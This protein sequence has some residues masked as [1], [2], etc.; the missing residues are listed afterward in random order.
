MKKFLLSVHVIFLLCS[1]IASAAVIPNGSFSVTQSLFVSGGNIGTGTPAS[2]NFLLRFSKVGETAS[3]KISNERFVLNGGM[4]L[5]MSRVGGDL[6]RVHVRGTIDDPTAIVYVNEVCAVNQGTNWV[7]P[8]VTVREG[9]NRLYV[10][11]FDP[12]E[13]ISGTVVTVTVDTR[14]PAMPTAVYEFVTHLST[15]RITGVKDAASE[16]WVRMA[17]AETLIPGFSGLASWFYDAVLEE[18]ENHIEFFLADSAGNKSAAFPVDIVLD[19]DAAMFEII[20]PADGTRTQ[21]A[22]IDIAGKIYD[23]TATLTVNGALITFSENRGFF[24]V[25]NV[26]LAQAGANSIAIHAQ[27]ITGFSQDQVINIIRDDQ[28]LLPPTL[29]QLPPYAGVSDMSVSGNCDVDGD[30]SIRLNQGA[31]TNIGCS[32]GRWNY[33]LSFFVGENLVMV[34]GRDALGRMIAGEGAV[35]FLDITPPTS[36]VV[37]DGGSTQSSTSKLRV[38]WFSYDRETS[39]VDYEYAVST[40]PGPPPSAF[41]SSNGSGQVNITGD[42]KLNKTYYIHVRARNAAGLF[43]P[44]G[45]SDGI[46]ISDNEIPTIADLLPEI[47]EVRYPNEPIDWQ[48][49]A[50]DPDDDILQFKYALNGQTVFHFSEKPKRTYQIP[51]G[52]FG[53]QEVLGVVRDDPQSTFQEWPSV[54]TSFYVARRPIEP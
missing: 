53:R 39:V 28:A 12:Q 5:A 8:F 2:E 37:S 18:G 14:P 47:G 41:V 32:A 21:S 45:V 11:S 54:S 42:Y 43:S 16:L 50:H 3:V 1:G 33:S 13:N 20:A 44:T 52:M 46:K 40:T 36:P 10:S 35:V 27:S 15:Q 23:D 31:R 30:V 19:T 17:D 6:M 7:A 4:N 25:K 24:T 29:D 38:N 9:E 48:L 49:I 34:E 26:H 22:A 51:N